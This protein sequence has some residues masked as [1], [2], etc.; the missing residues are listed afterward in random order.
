MC[1]NKPKGKIHIALKSLLVWHI[2]PN[3]LSRQ[4][5]LPV[6]IMF[7]KKQLGIML[8]FHTKMTQHTLQILRRSVKNDQ[9]F[10]GG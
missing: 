1:V 4:K 3:A 9:F 8:T 2:Q 10:G 6:D 7:L 5:L